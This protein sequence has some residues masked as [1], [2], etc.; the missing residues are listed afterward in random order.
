MTGWSVAGSV[1]AARSAATGLSRGEEFLHNRV[2]LKA[3]MSVWD[4]PS[5]Q[6][7]KWNHA[8]ALRESLHLL[9]TKRL[10]LDGF[11]GARYP[12]AEAAPAFKSLVAN[13]GQY[14]KIALTYP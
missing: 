11:V 9:A 6:S 2:T 8:R 13:P 3:S 1:L 10:R 7:D 12:F 4:C 14:L 5:R